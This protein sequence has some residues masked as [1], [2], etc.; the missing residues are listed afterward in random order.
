MAEFYTW[1]EWPGFNDE[2][3]SA[4]ESI[5]STIP[6]DCHAWGD[7]MNEVG[8]FTGDRVLIRGTAPSKKFEKLG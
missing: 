4:L 2:T 7:V 5:A 6:D 1:E 8:I 3:R